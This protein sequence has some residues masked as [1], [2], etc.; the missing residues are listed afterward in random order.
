MLLSAAIMQK[1]GMEQAYYAISSYSK[2]NGN[3]FLYIS[4]EYEDIVSKL[5]LII[6]ELK[7][8]D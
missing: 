5:E 8:T 6:T 2:S 3:C 7:R 1:Q 4:K